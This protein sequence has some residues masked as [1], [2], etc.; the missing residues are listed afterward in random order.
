MCPG[1]PVGLRRYRV[2][3]H[4]VSV[5]LVRDDIGLIATNYDENGQQIRHI[6]LELSRTSLSTIVTCS[7]LQFLRNHSNHHEMLLKMRM[8]LPTHNAHHHLHAK[9]DPLQLHRRRSRRLLANVSTS[10]RR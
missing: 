10:A 3:F 2:S 9:T 7:V 4:F 8:W 1:P 6:L 5:E